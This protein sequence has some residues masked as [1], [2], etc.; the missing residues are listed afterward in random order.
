MIPQG[1][2]QV[3][4]PRPGAKK[5]TYALRCRKLRNELDC[6]CLVVISYR[7][8]GRMSCYLFE[9]MLLVGVSGRLRLET[10]VRVC[11]RMPPI[12]CCVCAAGVR[13]IKSLA[14]K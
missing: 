11:E 6:R 5:T 14:W 8:H 7:L 1:K 12:R 3:G 10:C 9:M 13:M 2:E 4:E